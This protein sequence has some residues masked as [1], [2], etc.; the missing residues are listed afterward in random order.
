MPLLGAGGGI[1]EAEVIELIS[2]NASSGIRVW[3]PGELA[4]TNYFDQQPDSAYDGGGYQLQP[5]ANAPDDSLLVVQPVDVTATWTTYENNFPT[6]WADG[7]PG[8]QWVGGNCDANS[9]IQ[10][11]L[12]AAYPVASIEWDDTGEHTGTVSELYYAGRI[13]V[14]EDGTNFVDLLTYSTQVHPKWTGTPHQARYIRVNATR[15]SGNWTAINGLVVKYAADHERPDFASFVKFINTDGG[16]PA[17]VLHL[18]AISALAGK[19]PV[20][21][22]CW[23]DFRPGGGGER[24]FK[25]VQGGVTKAQISSVNAVRPTGWQPMVANLAGLGDVTFQAMRYSEAW[26]AGVEVYVEPEHPFMLN[27]LCIYDNQIYQSKM[28][29]NPNEPG[30]DGTWEIKLAQTSLSDLEARVA[31]L[32]ALL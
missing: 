25:I 22:K 11:D 21:L 17:L 26:L 5:A 7:N 23:A 10:A 8:T 18:S 15:T 3:A 27:D 28:D 31:A 4:Y 32:E 29:A 20:Q 14:S 16:A 9:Y 19:N 24:D 6:Y 13:S 12:G 1:S 2:G 30:T